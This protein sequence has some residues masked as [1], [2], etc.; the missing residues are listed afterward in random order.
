MKTME[1]KLREEYVW[2]QNIIKDVK[3][4]LLDAPKGQL[5][6]TKKRKGVEY[7][8]KEDGRKPYGLFLRYG[9]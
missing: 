5:R 4:R 8:Y 9:C 2:L 6:I 7:Y 1:E 3:G